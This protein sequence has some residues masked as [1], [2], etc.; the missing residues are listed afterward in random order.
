MSG[1]ETLQFLRIDIE[2][3][4]KDIVGALAALVDTQESAISYAGHDATSM[5]GDEGN[6][7]KG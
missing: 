1:K 5:P 2:E 4:L 6:T 7:K 3:L